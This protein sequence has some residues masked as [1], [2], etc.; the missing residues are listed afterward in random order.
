MNPSAISTVGP[1]QIGLSIT[2]GVGALA[3]A[4]HGHHTGKFWWLLGGYIVGSSMGYLVD[5]ETG[6][7]A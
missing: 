6:K 7:T 3:Y 2:I 1:W 4:I 5:Y